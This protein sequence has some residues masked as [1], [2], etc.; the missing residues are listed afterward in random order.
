MRARIRT[1]KPEIF[2]D[3]K[4]WDL[5][6]STGWPVYQGFQGLWCYADREGRFEWRPKALAALILPYWGGDF[7]ALLEVLVAA[8]MVA[9]Y[10]VGGREYGLVV[11]LPEHQAFN[12]REPAS[13]LP[14]PPP[15]TC[16]HVH[17]CA[18]TRWIGSDRIG[19]G[20]DLSLADGEG[21]GEVEPIRDPE[22]SATDD[23]EPP[24]RRWPRYPPGWKWS[25]ATQAAAAAH[26]VTSLELQA[27]VAYWT[28]HP[29]GV[30]VCDL[31]GETVRQLKGIVERRPKH[32]PP[33]SA[34]GG[35]GI[36]DWSPKDEHRLFCK[37]RALPL[38]YAVEAYREAGTPQ[39]LTSTQRTDEDFAARLR[40][41]A[42][43]GEF[44]PSGKAPQPAK[45]V[46]AC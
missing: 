21:G 22:P 14:P 9:R 26:G 36:Y 20:T 35:V 23:P 38:E 24:L 28:T 39:Q 4:L 17:A 30:P 43:H 27:H 6:V 10:T 7:E 34:P 37:A 1:V 46:G 18:C 32:A 44:I 19:S 15:G 2:H 31:D 29:F 42:E 25:L 11:N 12:A 40:W 13:K 45:A 8:R 33:A 3:E 41:W 5:G 16:T